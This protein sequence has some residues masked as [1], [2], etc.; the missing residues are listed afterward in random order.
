MG[1]LLVV[2]LLPIVV[3]P[4]NVGLAVTNVELLGSPV[5]VHVGNDEAVITAVMILQ[6]YV[7]GVRTVSISS[8]EEL[9]TLVLSNVAVFLVGHGNFEGLGTATQ[10]V[11]TWHLIKAF[12]QTYSK[13]N[14]YVVACGPVFQ[15]PLFENHVRFFTTDG[16]REET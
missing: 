9:G 2:I 7:P 11:L 10:V 1:L 6:T 3:T 5:V 15:T 14:V 4:Y 8:A 16:P 12:L 13:T